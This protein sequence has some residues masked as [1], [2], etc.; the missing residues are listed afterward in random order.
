MGN[1][2]A[3]SLNG[4]RKFYYVYSQKLHKYLIE[5]SDDM[6]IYVLSIVR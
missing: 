6:S 2:K 4:L 5:E 1:C 3:S